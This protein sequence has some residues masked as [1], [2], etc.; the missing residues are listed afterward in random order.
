MIT[1]AFMSRHLFVPIACLLT[2]AACTVE[3]DDPF[4]SLTSAAS[5]AT[6]NNNMDTLE[7]EGE[8]ESGD[9]DG[10]TGD[11]D[12]DT[13]DGDGDSGD[14]DPGDGDGDPGDGDGDGDP[15]DGDPG[16]GDGDTG[17]QMTCGWFDDPTF[18]GYYCDGSGEDPEGIHPIDCPPGLADGAPCG[19]L[20]GQGCCDNAGNNWY[21]GEG[22][23]VVF[24]GCR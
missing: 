4:T 2:L 15:G 13:G 10:D 23:V 19:E 1:S 20:T 9:G 22:N 7:A 5:L 17:M 8:S 16:D 11:G 12:G 24:I 3:P 6:T 21:C 18:P 14:G